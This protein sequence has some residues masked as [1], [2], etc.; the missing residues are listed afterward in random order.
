M[1]AQDTVC[2]DYGATVEVGGSYAAS[3]QVL[4]F[5]RLL[6]VL[7]EILT[8]CSVYHGRDNNHDILAIWVPKPQNA[9]LFE[10]AK[11]SC[12]SLF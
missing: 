9:L 4:T 3:L 6:S 5:L 7:F 1:C 8:K 12:A 2:Q 11:A 10:H